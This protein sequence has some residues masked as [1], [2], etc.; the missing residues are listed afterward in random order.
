MKTF[1]NRIAVV[2]GAASGI[3]RAVAVALAEKGCHLSVSDKNE[4][5]LAETAQQIE[6]TGRRVSQHLIDVSKAD[7]V[8]RLVSEVEREH[9]GANIVINNAG[10]SV[11]KT[12]ED[13]T[14]EDFEWLMGV[15]FWGVVYGCKFFLPLLKKADEGHIVNI[16]SLFGIIGTPMNSSYCASKFAVRGLSESLRVELA[17]SGVGVTSI[18]PGGIATNIV[19]EGRWGESDRDQETRR[20]AVS[21]FK[22]MMPPEAAARRIVEAIGANKQRVLITKEAYVGDALQRLAPTA[23]SAIVTREWRRFQDTGEATLSRLE[24]L[25]GK[26]N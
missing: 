12:F 18:H 16:S 24:K 26:K 3:G 8:K 6:R 20:N 14:I 4:A 7:E 1:E 17:G 10:V 11:A 5:G 23:L 2:T 13:T 15:N 19:A 22:N 25:I 21:S 9:G